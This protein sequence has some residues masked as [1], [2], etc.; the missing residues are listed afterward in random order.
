MHFFFFSVLTI[1]FPNCLNWEGNDFSF[2]IKWKVNL[3]RPPPHFSILIQKTGFSKQVRLKTTRTVSQA[4]F[5]FRFQENISGQRKQQQSVFP[6]RKRTEKNILL[7][8]RRNLWIK[9]PTT[10]H[11][12]P[13]LPLRLSFF[14]SLTHKHRH[15]VQCLRA[16]QG[17]RPDY[18]RWALCSWGLAQ[19]WEEGEDKHTVC[20][21]SDYS[22][23]CVCFQHCL[24]LLTHVQSTS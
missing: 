4:H 11:S 3:K 22:M 15:I 12:F 20:L 6:Y 24:W 10:A 21:L 9:M 23:Q 5:L 13:A 19:R 17:A 2:D 16:G 8:E 7:C 18:S 14:F 1:C